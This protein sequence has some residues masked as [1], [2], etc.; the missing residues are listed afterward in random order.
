[1]YTVRMLN[2][3]ICS[4]LRAFA[5]SC[6][7]ITMAPIL[8]IQNDQMTAWIVQNYHWW[9]CFSGWLLA[10]IS[11]KWFDREKPSLPYP[12]YGQLW[13]HLIPPKKKGHLNFRPE[14][15]DLFNLHVAFLKQ[16]PLE[17]LLPSI[18][19]E[20]SGHQQ[21]LDLAGTICHLAGGKLWK[22]RGG[23]LA[24]VSLFFWSALE[25]GIISSHRYFPSFLQLSM[26]VVTLRYP[27][28]IKHLRFGVWTPKNM[29]KTPF[30]SGGNS[31]GCQTFL[32]KMPRWFL[33]FFQVWDAT[34]GEYP[35]QEEAGGVSHGDAP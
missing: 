12:I 8:F 22:S 26:F 11:P 5:L 32:G 17:S 25:F 16:Y 30:M 9:L 6:F 3:Y 27:N 13:W 35:E 7:P 18:L 33:R 31:P 34:I 1:M 20:T 28:T 2:L 21:Q 29:R 19:S 4:Q 15:L 10:K 24:K 23:K 14:P